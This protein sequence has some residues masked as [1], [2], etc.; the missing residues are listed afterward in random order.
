[1]L[2]C[3]RIFV[4]VMAKNIDHFLNLTVEIEAFDNFHVYLH[5]HTKEEQ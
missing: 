5:G 3:L 1:M 4:T 2:L